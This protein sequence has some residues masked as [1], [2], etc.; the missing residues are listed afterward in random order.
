MN[1]ESV[2]TLF[3]D[4]SVF[5]TSSLSGELDLGRLVRAS[6]NYDAE[7]LDD[8]VEMNEQISILERSWI[9]WSRRESIFTR[10]PSS[11]VLSTYGAPLDGEWVSPCGF[12]SKRL[13]WRRG[14][15]LLQ[16]SD[17]CEDGVPVLAEDMEMIGLDGTQLRYRLYWGMNT[18]PQPTLKRLAVRFLGFG[19]GER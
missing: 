7:I 19:Y 6:V 10:T 3:D 11:S 13:I 1:S 15:K 17:V 8:P 2:S 18:E 12:Y 4:W 5:I 16:L 9:G 14:W